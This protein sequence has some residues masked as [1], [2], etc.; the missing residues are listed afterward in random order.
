MNYTSIAR[1]SFCAA[2]I[3]GFSSY[4]SQTSHPFLAGLLIAIPIA[5]PSLW[6]IENKNAKDMKEYLRGFCIS[7]IIYCIVVLFFYYMVVKSNYDKK[8][9]IILAMI[10]WAVIMFICYQSLR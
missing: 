2:V 1:A 3:I 7:I 10:L 4:L 5:L 8:K 6:F 9:M